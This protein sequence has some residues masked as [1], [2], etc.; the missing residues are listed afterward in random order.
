MRI[1]VDAMGGDHGPGPV[2][3]GALEALALDG[4]LE[5]TLVGDQRLVQPL[6]DEFPEAAGRIRFDH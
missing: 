6:A 2:V 1:A 4:E 5:L 3:Q